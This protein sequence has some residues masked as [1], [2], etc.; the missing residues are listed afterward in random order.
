MKRLSSAIVLLVV[1]AVSL[2]AMPAG[3]QAGAAQTGGMQVSDAK[4]GK[5]VENREIKDETTT[6]AVGDKAYLWL[7]VTG[8]PGDL[9]VTW[10]NGDLTDTVSL[11]IGGSSWR[12]WS[13]KTLGKAGSWTVTVADGSGTTLKELT[14]TVQ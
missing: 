1:A 11:T 9:K 2:A 13:T 12:T 5:G 8:G 7:K 14:L 3:A 4:L 6:F 10:K